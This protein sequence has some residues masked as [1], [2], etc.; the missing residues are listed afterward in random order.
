M[1]HLNQIHLFY[2]I[3][4]FI[5]TRIDVAPII[6]HRTEANLCPLPKVIISYFRDRHI[7]SM[8]Y[9]IDQFPNHMSLSLQGMIFR[10][11]KVKVANSDD[12]LSPLLKK[13]TL[14][15]KPYRI[16]G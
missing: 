3:D 15:W 5:Q 7:K 4:H 1:D 2:K 6:S 8:S 12:H 10:N 14:E 16:S 13:G 11:P 9:P